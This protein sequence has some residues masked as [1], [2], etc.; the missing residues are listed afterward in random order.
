MKSFDFFVQ[1]TTML[2]RMLI[3][4]HCRRLLSIEVF[5]WLWE[6]AL[7]VIYISHCNVIAEGGILEVQVI[8][9]AST[10]ALVCIVFT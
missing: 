3:M 1:E 7:L 8:L 10:N 9:I 2:A 5:Y 6:L 4:K